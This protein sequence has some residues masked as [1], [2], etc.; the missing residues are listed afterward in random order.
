M[1][2]TSGR[3]MG[4]V[5][6]GTAFFKKTFIFIDFRRERERERVIS[7]MRENH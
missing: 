5:S 6:T 2:I 4:T 3:S 1:S 7:M